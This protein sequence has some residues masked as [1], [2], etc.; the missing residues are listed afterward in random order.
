M[1]KIIEESPI[2]PLQPALYQ[3]ILCLVPNKLKNNPNVKELSNQLKEEIDYD[4]IE[5]IKKLN[6]WEF[7]PV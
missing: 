6:G 1:K 7:Y 3:R 2:T 5:T 4:F